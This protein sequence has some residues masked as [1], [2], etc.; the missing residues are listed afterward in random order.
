MECGPHLDVP[1]H[2]ADCTEDGWYRGCRARLCAR[3]QRNRREMNRFYN[4]VHRY[5]RRYKPIPRRDISLEY[6]DTWLDESNYSLARKRVLKDYLVDYL[7]GR[8]KNM[9]LC[10]SFVKREI[11][12][13]MKEPR[14]INSR[15]DLFKAVVGPFIHEAEKTIYDEHFVKGLTPPEIAVKLKQ[16]CDGRV[17]SE[18]D[19][20]R[21]ECSIDWRFIRIC[22]KQ[23]LD[24]LLANNPVILRHIHV[25]QRRS[26]LYYHWHRARLHMRGGRMSGDMWTSS[27]NGFTNKMLMEYMLFR[28]QAVGDYIVEGDDG[29]ITADRP[30]DFGIAARLGFRL[31]IEHVHDINQM[32]FCGIHVMPSGRPCPDPHKMAA[33]FG[34]VHLKRYFHPNTKR[35][36]RGV[37]GLLK[38]KALSALYLAAGVPVIQEL[39]V[40]VIR[41]TKGIR[42]NWSEFGWWQK[43]FKMPHSFVSPEPVMDSDRTWFYEQW[44]VPIRTQLALEEEFSRNMHIRVRF[45]GL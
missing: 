3:L 32:S 20:T 36:K 7:H 44:G 42:A 8:R 19:Y 35:K 2:M 26:D 39:A 12:L 5:V 10:S 30:L 38:A 18:T 28:A 4:F 15:T 13:E 29:V 40:M 37:M 31:K 34:W 22:E 6:M 9:Y 33:K 43:Q 24:R 11:M 45:D 14:I 27:M 41:L 16:F 17:F 23:L 21:F 25:A 1:V